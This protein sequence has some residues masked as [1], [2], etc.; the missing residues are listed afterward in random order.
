MT[1]K[2]LRLL[3]VALL[4]AGGRARAQIS[5]GG[6]TVTDGTHTVTNATTAAFT[7]GCVVGAGG[8]GTADVTCS[9][10][11][12]LQPAN[13]AISYGADPTGVADSTTAIN[14]CLA[15]TQ[16][17]VVRNAY[18]P[19]GTYHIT[20]ALLVGSA[21]QGQCLQGDGDS[22]ILDVSNDFNS[23]ALGVIVLNG[24]NPTTN[25]I[26][27][28]PCVKDITIQFHEPPDQVCTVATAAAA[29][30]TTI[31]LNAGCVVT[32]GDYVVDVTT[33]NAISQRP[34]QAN[35]TTASLAGNVLTVSPA[36][37][38]GGTV[39]V[40]DTLD[41][42]QVRA[43]FVS[44]STAPVLTAGAPGIAYPVG[45]YGSGDGIP[46]IDNVRMNQA[47][48]C[49]YLHGHTGTG[50]TNTFNAGRIRCGSLN[51][52][53]DV[54]TIFS[55]P[56]VDDFMVWDFGYG[57]V[58]TIGGGPA[59][60]LNY[61]DG[62]NV[63]AKLGEADG[64]TITSL[65]CW[66][67]SVT[68]TPTWS[69]GHF[70]HVQMDGSGAFLANGTLGEWT[71]ISNFYSTSTNLT[72][73]PVTVSSGYVQIANFW[74]Q[75]GGGGAEPGICVTG[76]NLRIVNG[77]MLQNATGE[78]IATLT[79]GV[80]EIDA[81]SLLTSATAWSVGLIQQTGTAGT[82]IMQ[83][84]Q[85]IGGGRNLADDALGR[86]VGDMG[87]ADDGHHMMLA[88]AFHTYVAQHHHFVVAAALL[89][90]AL[91]ILPRVG[92]VAGEQLAVRLGHAFGGV[93]QPLAVGIV[94]GPTD[95]GAD[96]RFGVGLGG[97]INLARRVHKSSNNSSA[98]A[99]NAA[100]GQGRA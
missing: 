56:Q 46:V 47:Y 11:G 4:L 55:S 58:S 52:G 74:W 2:M 15:S 20:N 39:H 21:T 12:A 90:G 92:L 38:T 59:Y 27:T 63:C 99:E 88:I 53:L 25:G 94:A 98:G 23:S 78:P 67:S 91:Q 9:G 66:T 14:T 22:T 57:S 19:S 84:D 30:A 50:G 70:A 49:V 29:G 13:C 87:A 24:Q 43:N 40:G 61:Y 48:N 54:D 32:S 93:E 5:P 65:Q 97:V 8:F 86:Q 68:L 81:A 77:S 71:Q 51:V 60:S 16:Y 31:T 3:A 79:G 17:G 82:L 80:L 18:L 36:V 72:T 62:N 34:E 85:F 89:E 73:C 69:W 37:L 44:L 41:F 1:R 33:A 45:I 42:A 64:I 7:S 96:G 83:N 28:A 76:G 95:Q 6:Q 100:R 75:G 10:T 26:G 35:S